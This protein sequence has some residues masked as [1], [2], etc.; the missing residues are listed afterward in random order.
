MGSNA[1][2]TGGND[3][4]PTEGFANPGGNPA[5]CPVASPP[6]GPAGGGAAATGGGATGGGGGV[7]TPAKANLAGAKSTIKVTAGRFSYVFRA[8][9]LLKG[10]ASF[11]SINKVK[12]SALKKVTLAKKSFTVP[13]SGKVTLKIKLSRKNL[14]ILR[15]NRKIK[16]RVTITLHNA[17]GRTSTATRALTLKI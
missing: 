7:T 5:V 6:G 2:T 4:S 14:K 16:L 12:V 17:A 8:G 9:A 11:K 3:T 10:S 13:T 15:R 1:S